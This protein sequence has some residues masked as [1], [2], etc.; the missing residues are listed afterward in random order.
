MLIVAIPKL[1]GNGVVA[2]RGVRT[3]DYARRWSVSRSMVSDLVKRG[4]PT[5]HFSRSCVRVLLP[6]GDRWLR[7]HFSKTNGHSQEET[8]C[9]KP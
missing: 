5:I 7:S 9:P 8:P 6:E 4:L 3:A 1:N 2:I